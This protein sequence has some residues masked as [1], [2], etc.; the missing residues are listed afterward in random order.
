MLT[1]DL[2]NHDGVY[3][4]VINHTIE[5]SR[6]SMVLRPAVSQDGDMWCALYGDNIAEG[7]AAF[8]KTPDEAMR[9]FDRVWETGS[10]RFYTEVMAAKRAQA[11]EAADND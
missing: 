10:D 2:M 4:A 6:P 9:R 5:M 8:G 7:V 1:A 3:N 11:E